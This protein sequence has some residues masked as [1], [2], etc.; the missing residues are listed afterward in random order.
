MGYDLLG[1]PAG[2][3]GQ[4][5]GVQSRH[6]V[7]APEHQRTRRPSAGP[8]RATQIGVRTEHARIGQ[9][10]QGVPAGRVT[11]VEHLG[12]QDHLHVKLEGTDFVVLADPDAGLAAGDEVTV[13]L[14]EPLFFD[15]AGER[16]RA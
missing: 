3:P 8:A 6:A 16:V 10:I 4:P 13:T 2:V 15:K 12:E 7:E 5:P 11:W 14:S 1:Q 9:P